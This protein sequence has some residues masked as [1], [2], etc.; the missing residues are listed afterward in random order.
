VVSSSV[1]ANA[2][3]KWP[4]ISRFEATIGIGK[5]GE[6][7]YFQIPIQNLQGKTEYTLFGIGGSEEYLD[8]LS[9]ET[10]IWHVG[11]LMITLVEGTEQSEGSLL[12]EDS[13]PFWFSRG[14]V[15]CNYE[16]LVGAYGRYPEFGVLRHFRLRGF[17]LTLRFFDIETDSKGEVQFVKLKVTVL[18]CPACTTAQAER[19]GFLSPYGEGR[20][21]E[22][23]LV[24]KEPL[25]RRDEDG[26]WY[27]EKEK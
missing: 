14:Q 27:E 15:H 5:A 19:P 23:V 21:P 1:Q 8:Q 4:Q 3:P 2:I 22:K 25:M 17:E 10:N 16:D 9:D 7:I 6:R 18:P 26:S 24:G 13:S 20:S 12:C 11:P